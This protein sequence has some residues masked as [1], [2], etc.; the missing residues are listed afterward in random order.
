VGLDAGKRHAHTLDAQL[1]ALT[2]VLD[3][4]RAGSV[5][6][7]HS[8]RSAAIVLDLLEKSGL[9]NSCSCIFH[10]YSDDGSSLARAVRAGCLFSVG[11]LMLRSRRGR[12]YAR[13][14]PLRQLLLETDYPEQSGH[15]SADETAEEMAEALQSACEQIA[16]LRG[17]EATALAERLADSSLRVIRG[18]A[19]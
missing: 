8:V 11:P 14:L 1:A 16:A 3:A 19:R 12:E 5:L 15:A 13:Q 9:T 4:V 6:S 17:M 18:L 2:S 7:L 10:W